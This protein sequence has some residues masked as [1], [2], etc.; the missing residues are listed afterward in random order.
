MKN[1]PIASAISARGLD[2]PA[3]PIDMSEIFREK[4]IKNVYVIAMT[5][6]CGSTWL[7]SELRALPNCGNP[8]EYFSEEMI[9]YVEPNVTFRNVV[10]L[11]RSI[12]DNGRT[13]DTFGFKIDGARL[14]NL[15][16]IVD[17]RSSF[18][19][20]V[21]KWIDMRRLNIVKQAF[22]FARAK[23]TGVWHIYAGADQSDQERSNQIDVNDISDT[24]VWR[25]INLLVRSENNLSKIY[26]ELNVIP[27]SIKYEEMV[28][29]KTQILIQSLAHLFPDRELPIIPD[30]EEGKT[31]KLSTAKSNPNELSFIIRNTAEVNKLNAIR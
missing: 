10:D 9:P 1:N 31:L 14:E 8:N 23:R 29:S 6:R 5:G 26:Q 2:A 17:I 30:D 22:S 27:L 21:A 28:D 20:S 11:L 7:A 16:E 18:G 3:L 24:S 4:G 13:G 19:P 12:V 15:S 25:E